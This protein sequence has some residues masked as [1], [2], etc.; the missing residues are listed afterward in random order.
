MDKTSVSTNKKKRKVSFFAGVKVR[1]ILHIND[2][3]DEEI[4]TC[5]YRSR[6]YAAMKAQTKSTLI[7]LL[8]HGGSDVDS[9]EHCA[10]GLE[11]K[12]RMGAM[13]RR[14]NKMSGWMAVLD[15]QSAQLCKES[16]NTVAISEAYIAVTKQCAALAHSKGLMD[17]AIA[18]TGEQSREHT[19]KHESEEISDQVSEEVSEEVPEEAP[20]PCN[21]VVKK[22]KK[23]VGRL[24]RIFGKK[25]KQ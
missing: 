1:N 5:W 16:E 20:L 24:S 13:Q 22:G 2:F 4:A 11:Y 7:V 3:S 15:L 8:K 17:E 12:T 19:P 21:K 9:N 18:F 25:S 23:R 10:R 6:E 14:T